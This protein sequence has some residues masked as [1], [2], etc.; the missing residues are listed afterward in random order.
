MH[1][2]IHVG[3]A[4]LEKGHGVKAGDRI[5]AHHPVYGDVEGTVRSVHRNGNLVAN[6]HSSSRGFGVQ[7]G[8]ALHRSSVTAFRK[9]EG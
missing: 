3:A 5:R 7:P 6:L 8:V 4:G 1:G 9:G 2:W